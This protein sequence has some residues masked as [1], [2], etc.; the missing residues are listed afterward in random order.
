MRGQRKGVYEANVHCYQPARKIP[1]TDRHREDRVAFALHQLNTAS[2]EDWDRTIWTDKKVFCSADDRH[3]F[4]SKPENH[5]FDPK[6]ALPSGKS[7]RITCAVWGWISAHRPGEL[8]EVSSHMDALEYIDILENV[9]LPSVCRIYSK[10]DMPTFRLVQ[11]NSA[12]H[13]AHI[14]QE[15]PKHL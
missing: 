3:K 2:P 4:V 10:G 15:L 7:G 14:V 12:V 8:V 11:D 9:L 1:L 5:R 6:Y 13:T